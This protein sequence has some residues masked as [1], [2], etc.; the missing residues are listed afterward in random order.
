[1]WDFL[2]CNWQTVSFRCF[3]LLPMIMPCVAPVFVSMRNNPLADMSSVTHVLAHSP[4]VS[5]MIS[6]RLRLTHSHTHPYSSIHTQIRS[7]ADSLIFRFAVFQSH[8]HSGTRVAMSNL[9][10]GHSRAPSRSDCGDV[11]SDALIS[12]GTRVSFQVRVTI[13][14]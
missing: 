3:F 4:S 12:G 11:L 13:A 7:H 6:L 1:M 8:S 9:A 14:M 5:F 10:P 2:L